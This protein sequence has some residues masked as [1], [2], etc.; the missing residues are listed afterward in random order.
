MKNKREI[1][2]RA[3]HPLNKE[4]VYQSTGHNFGYEAYTNSSILKDFSEEN[5]MQFTGLQDKNGKDIYEGDVVRRY[6]GYV[7][8]TKVRE[9]RLGEINQTSAYGYGWHESDEI[10]GNI[11]ENPEFLPK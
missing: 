11:Y 1:K 9:Y 7:F 4:I 6:T 8:E 10:I 2:F 3:W 5:I